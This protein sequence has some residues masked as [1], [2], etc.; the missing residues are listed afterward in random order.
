V[1]YA[2][3]K[4]FWTPYR[5]RDTLNSSAK[6]FSEDI[7]TILSDYLRV[8]SILVYIGRPADIVSF[9][10]Y[11]LDDASLPLVGLP[12]HWEQAPPF[13]QLFQA[14]QDH[15]WLFCP[16]EFKAKLH[17]RVL[18]KRHV[19]PVTY[20]YRLSPEITDLDLTIV[21]KVEIHESCNQLVPKV[22]SPYYLAAEGLL[23]YTQG[24]VAFKVYQT[25]DVAE[26]FEREIAIYVNLKP[27]SFKYI[28][29][30]FGSFQQG[31]KRTVILEYADGG[32]LLDFFRRVP[33]PRSL[34]DHTALWE[35]LI[36]LLQGLY[37]VHNLTLDEGSWQFRG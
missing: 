28:I 7:G 36:E 15:Q 20:Q 29:N 32:N 2:S 5:V 35:N 8:W 23:T 27:E 25:D 12:H 19:L 24:V 10:R 6:H 33:H 3:L 30:Y 37:L 16:L 9:T 11:K 31:D 17:N 1:P 4:A 34:N 26:L 14:F 18:D 13:H 21:H 22:G